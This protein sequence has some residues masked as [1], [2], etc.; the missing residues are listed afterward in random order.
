M[1]A[2]TS[3][4][5]RILYLSLGVF[6]LGLGLIGIALPLIPTVVPVLLAAFFFS[7]SSER[8]HNRILE[9][10]LLGGIVRDW[11]AGAGFTLRAKTL[12]IAATITSFTI[13]VVFIV[14]PTVIRVS[15]IALAVALIVYMASIPT[16]RVAPIPA[17]LPQGLS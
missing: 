8:L 16:K 10:R 17:Q 5:L 3:S 15:L 13:S 14:D 7:K 2:I 11:Q 12:A 1:S 4:A 9:H 6:F